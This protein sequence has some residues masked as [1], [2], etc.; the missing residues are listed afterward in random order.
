MEKLAKTGKAKVIG[1]S[2]FS[3]VELETLIEQSATVSSPMA[4]N[5]A[6]DFISVRNQLMR[7]EDTR[8]SSDGSAYLSAAKAF[9]PV[10]SFQGHSCDS[11][12]PSGEH[13]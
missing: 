9:Q 7:P 4:G 12:Q 1:V 10:A 3:K 2:N 6:P 11:V 8:C 5:S 13:E